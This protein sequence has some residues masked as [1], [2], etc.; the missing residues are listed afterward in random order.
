MR[1]RRAK[2]GGVIPSPVEIRKPSLRDRIKN[3]SEFAARDIVNEHPKV[4]SLRSTIE[5]RVAGAVKGALRD[6]RAAR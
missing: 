2:G 5:R 6:V 3:A 4:V 1:R